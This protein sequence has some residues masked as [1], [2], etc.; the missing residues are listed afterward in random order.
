MCL[1]G[2]SGW[3]RGNPR[4]LLSGPRLKSF[5]IIN[6]CIEQCGTSYRGGVRSDQTQICAIVML[7]YSHAIRMKA[8]YVKTLSTRVIC[9]WLVWLF[10]TAGL[11]R[12]LDLEQITEVSVSLYVE[13][14]IAPDL[15]LSL[16]HTQ[17][18][19][20]FLWTGRPVISPARASLSPQWWSA[21]QA[22]PKLVPRDVLTQT[23]SAL[24]WTHIFLFYF[25]FH[26]ICLK[27]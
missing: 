13:L 9:E 25:P 22:L 5:N 4:W 3:V 16:T 10:L 7:A 14:T 12:C 11:L 26:N 23:W 8:A 18:S 19:L 2:N 15:L 21:A 27:I 20:C 24:T 1:L 17:I 6:V